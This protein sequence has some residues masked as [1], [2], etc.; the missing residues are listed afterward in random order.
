MTNVE[1]DRSETASLNESFRDD[2]TES[3]SGSLV[4][5]DNIRPRGYR[6]LVKE[7]VREVVEQMLESG[8]LVRPGGMSG[9]PSNKKSRPFRE[10][11]PSRK[12][13]GYAKGSKSLGKSK[14]AA[15]YSSEDEEDP[16]EEM[17]HTLRQL[18]SPLLHVPENKIHD[19]DSF[20]YLGGDSILA[21][22]L[23]R[24]ARDAGLRLAVADIFGS[25]VFSD[26]AETMVISAQNKNQYDSSETQ[27]VA[28]S[29]DRHGSS[30]T[31]HPQPF[32]LLQTAN[33]D[34]FVQDYICP[35]VGV[36]R[37]GIV[38]AFPVTDFQALAVAGTLLESRWMLNYLTFDGVGFFDLERV[39]RGASQLV[40]LFEILRTVFLPCGNRFIQVVLRSL[41]PR[42]HVHETDMDLG[43]YTR[44]L[45]EESPSAYPRLGEP[46]TQFMVIKKTGSHAHRIVLRLSHAQYD[47]VSLPRIIEAFQAAYEGTEMPPPSPPFSNY[48]REATTG[49]ASHGHHEYWK[50]LLHGASMTR[51]VDRQQPKYSGSDMSTTVLKQTI[52]LPALA[53]KNVTTATILKA[54]WTLVLAQLSGRN[55]VVFGGLISGRN[56]A[57]ESVE[58]IV[59]PCLNIV[60]IRIQLEPK[61]TALDLL[62]RIQNQQVAG[63]AFESLGFR[64]IVQHCTDW[65]GWTYFSSIVQHQNLAEDMSTVSLD[66]TR[67]KLGFLGSPDTLADLTLVSTPK[68]GDMVEV[69]LGFA[70]DGT[71][72]PSFVQRALDLTCFLA[73]NFASN[74][75]RTLPSA[76]ELSSANAITPQPEVTRQSID[77]SE[78]AKLEVT[79]RG[80]SKFEL[81]DIA[82]TLTRA[83]RIVLPK[84]RQTPSILTLESSFYDSGGDLISL[85]SLSAFLEGEG[86]KVRLEELIARP[87]VGAQVALLAEQRKKMA[88]RLGNSESSSETLQGSV[89]GEEEPKALPAEKKGL[90]GRQ[91]PVKEESKSKESKR[92]FWK[93][94]PARF[95]R[96]LGIRRVN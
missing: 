86:Y 87:T 57:V 8:V 41:R 33:T 32:S 48:V 27:S 21:M 25:P 76:S 58:S 4:I 96:R 24:Q 53:A 35:K 38:D 34:A 71:I 73:Q 15:Y 52:K 22:E 74:P 2:D 12:G 90:F 84:G 93:L 7:C 9:K 46:F 77:L 89:S 80:L 26:M 29:D 11:E 47:G 60:P 18:W 30:E 6:S 82:D 17:S 42:I 23:T 19:D 75:N 1:A 59:G 50:S 54:A 67:Y 64:E 37:S 66:R 16:L 49:D 10:F 88:I 62:R 83:W 39:R 85:A 13:K 70:D 28:A 14:Q 69:T 40:Q 51:V 44:Q 56:A 61:W 65:P 95:G 5:R 31:K 91:Q 92:A 3:T 79:L 36:F 72:A 81:C 43:E 68:G 55:D 94:K 20:F 45:R 63:M 78:S